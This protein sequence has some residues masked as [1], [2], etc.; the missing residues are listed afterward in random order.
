M[1]A[2]KS[3]RNNILCELCGNPLPP[4][5]GKGRPRVFHDDCRKLANILG[6]AEDLFDKIDFGPE[7]AAIVRRQ[8]WGMG[9]KVKAKGQ[10]GVEG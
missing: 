2:F 4:A 8:L 3:N 10:N 7:R 1:A 9:N 5:S 6:W